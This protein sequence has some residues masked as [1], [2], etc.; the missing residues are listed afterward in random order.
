M[1]GKGLTLYKPLPA[2]TCIRVLSL[3]GDH[4]EHS[5]NCTLSI[6]DPETEPVFQALSFQNHATWVGEFECDPWEQDPGH[7]VNDH[8]ATDSSRVREILLEPDHPWILLANGDQFDSVIRLLH[9][10][11]WHESGVIGD[12]F[13]SSHKG[14]IQTNQIGTTQD[15]VILGKTSGG[16]Y[17]TKD[18]LLHFGLKARWD[19]CFAMVTYLHTICW[20]PER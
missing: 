1:A 5:L 16:T 11:S 20:S 13:W 7:S 17:E 2:P 4:E 6:F 19:A 15:D 10:P 14:I 8:F 9:L 18:D 3:N 12:D